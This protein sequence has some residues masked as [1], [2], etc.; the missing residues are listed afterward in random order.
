MYV[1]FAMRTH[2]GTGAALLASGLQGLGVSEIID[3]PKN[4]IHDAVLKQTVSACMPA[5]SVC[6]KCI[7][8]DKK[9]YAES[10]R[11]MLF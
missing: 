7:E 5:G 1:M 9:Q 6:D 11:T 2:P 4:V 3:T 8:R 10:F